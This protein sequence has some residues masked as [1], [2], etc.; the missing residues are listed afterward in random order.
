MRLARG[1]KLAD[2]QPGVV[3]R[4]GWPAFTYASDS[5]Q[6]RLT[7]G[8][9]SELTV[10]G[11]PVL[12][13]P[14]RGPVT[15]G[16]L[17]D[18]R[19]SSGVNTP[20][21]AWVGEGSYGLFMDPA[22]GELVLGLGSDDHEDAAPLHLHLAK[23]IQATARGEAWVLHQAGGAPLA[24][25]S[26]SPLTMQHDP[27]R[28]QT[29]ALTPV[30]G[31][32]VSLRC[33]MPPSQW[34]APPTLVL[35]GN[36]PDH[37]TPAGEPVVIHWHAGGLAGEGWQLWGQV[38][39]LNTCALAHREQLPLV[40]RGGEAAGAWRL[41]WTQPGPW[42]MQ[43][44]LV[45]PAG[46]ATAFHG[47]F[48]YDLPS[49]RP[50]LPRPANYERFWRS[51]VA[52]LRSLPLEIAMNLRAAESSAEYQVFD[53]LITGWDGKRLQATYGEPT[54]HGRYPVSIGAGHRGANKEAVSRPQIC[55]LKY[56]MDGQAR[57]RS[58]W[59]SPYH[60]NLFH[61]IMDG[62]RWLD[63]LA[64]RPRADLGR[65]I[66][67]AG[68]RGGPV[69]L[70][71]LALDDRITRHIAN[72]PTNNAWLWQVT[73]PGSGG[74]WG[75]WP[76]DCPGRAERRHLGYFEPIH[77]AE[78]I[79][80]PCLLGLGLLDGLSQVTG[81]LAV[82]AR[83]GSLGHLCLRPWHG[84]DDASPAWYQLKQQ[85]ETEILGLTD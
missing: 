50:E 84:H 9:L 48:V 11:I 76:K 41:A 78:Q 46:V 49:Y 31:Q 85:W 61:N 81:N 21:S 70:G 2:P 43:L 16:T 34:P 13:P 45:S 37:Q 44:T 29:L 73:M 69:S 65:S 6:A 55:T 24:I 3:T 36:S 19:L 23:G 83:L 52:E 53:V 77:F 27:R 71:M 7:G 20:T 17:N 33:V 74:A 25:L 82:A 56:S 68:S 40:A 57:F 5:Y 18:G 32:R 66:L 38:E 47:V 26:G 63:F 30:Q 1:P 8:G 79:R 39:D 51:A 12:R 35:H 15:H 72:V 42:R 14:P 62:L 59:Y 67:Y 60:A 28:G 54:A 58:G 4:V 80:Q 64:T 10:G 75:P 22:P